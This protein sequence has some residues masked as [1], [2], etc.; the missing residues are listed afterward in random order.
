[1]ATIATRLTSTGT[2][3]NNGIFDEVTQSTISKSATAVFADEFD[4]VTISP[5]ANGL[6]QRQ[7][8]DGTLQVADEFDEVTGII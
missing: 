2:L 6:A 1:M 8:R 7:K 3:L 4:E 5:I